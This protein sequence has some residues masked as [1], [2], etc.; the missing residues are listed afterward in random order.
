MGYLIGIINVFRD[1]SK[2]Y[3]NS[4]LLLQASKN[5]KQS[6]RV[7]EIVGDYPGCAKGYEIWGEIELKKG[8]MTKAKKYFKNSWKYYQRMEVNDVLKVLYQ[9]RTAEKVKNLERKNE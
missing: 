7:A 9:T 6:I 1:L 2:S 4:G 8:N 3:I 5:I